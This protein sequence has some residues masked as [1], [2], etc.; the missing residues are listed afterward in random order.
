MSTFKII[1]ADD[2]T[3][4]DFLSKM[5]MTPQRTISLVPVG[6]DRDWVMTI[7]RHKVKRAFYLKD[8]GMRKYL[9]TIC[10]V[11]EY[12]AK[13]GDLKPSDPIEVNMDRMKEETEIEVSLRSNAIL[14]PPT[15]QFAT[16]NSWDIDRLVLTYS[17]ASKQCW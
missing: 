13:E 17:M 15:S 8:S 11:R 12:K 7:I 6:P 2:R 3:I 4:L 9:V 16:L 5:E 14:G 10:S 1:P